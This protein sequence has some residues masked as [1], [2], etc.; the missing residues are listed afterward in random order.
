[1][2]AACALGRVMGAAGTRSLS[3]REH[4]MHWIFPEASHFPDLLAAGRITKH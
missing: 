3:L 1:M 4:I 2:A